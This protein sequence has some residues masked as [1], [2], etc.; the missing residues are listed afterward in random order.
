MA[1]FIN[2][3]D[4]FKI[5]PIGQFYSD[6]SQVAMNYASGNT[7]VFT[8]KAEMDRAKRKSRQNQDNDNNSDDLVL[9]LK[10]KDEKYIKKE[11]FNSKSKEEHDSRVSVG[12]SLG[13]GAVFMAPS[14]V[15]AAQAKNNLDVAKM[16]FEF[17]DVAGKAKYADLFE[18]A[19]IAMQEA[20]EE[21]NKLNRRFKRQTKFA[22]RTKQRCVL[23]SEQRQLEKM[24]KDALASGN[25]DEVAKATAKLR[26]ANGTTLRKILRTGGSRLN[27]ANAAD[28]S[29][30]KAIKGN[31]LKHAI[32]GSIGW[33]MVGATAALTLVTDIPKIKQA[34][35]YDKASREQTGKDENLGWK[36]LG[37]SL[38]K[39]TPG[40]GYVGGETAVRMIRTKRL[41]KKS[42]LIAGKLVG[43]AGKK[44]GGKLAGK[45]GKK[46]A[47]KLAGKTGK[48]VAGRLLGR[49]AA[50]VAVKGGCKLAGTALGSVVPGIG[51]VIGFLVGTAIDLVLSHFVFKK[52]DPVDKKEID[53][54]PA[55]E[56]LFKLYLEDKAGKKVSPK[57]KKLINKNKKYLEALEQAQNAAIQQEAMQAQSEAAG[58]NQGNS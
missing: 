33:L 5:S 43:K 24:M 19:P 20:Q 58:S 10:N 22:V 1:P 14:I 50:K 51:N 37:K 7:S 44:A 54:A 36:Q 8:S 39:L 29:S 47:V 9:K 52:C 34:F 11:A 53:D 3:Q 27:L 16:F 30:V 57:A 21:M 25:A 28:V 46:A 23:H 26:A 49:I 35:S 38:L 41:S 6:G 48:K 45:A 15:Q 2:P 55:E 17:D 56:V 40:L 13:M 4:M 31:S 12:G 42:S 32:G 18:K